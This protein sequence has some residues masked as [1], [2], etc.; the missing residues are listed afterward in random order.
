MCWSF[1]DFLLIWDKIDSAFEKNGSQPEWSVMDEELS[2]WF[3]QKRSE[4]V[5]VSSPLLMAV[6]AEELGV[7]LN[8]EDFVCIVGCID[9]FKLCQHFLWGK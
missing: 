4:N 7:L 2:K 9:K 6:K 5:L 8:D 3:K 1:R